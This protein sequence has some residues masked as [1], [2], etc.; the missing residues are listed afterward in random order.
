MTK[1]SS[2]LVTASP[3]TRRW[4]EI[5]KSKVKLELPTVKYYEKMHWASFKNTSTNR[6]FAY[7][8]PTTRQIRLFTKLS[9]SSDSRLKS[10]PSTGEWAETYPSIFNIRSERDTEKAIH[11]II[12]SHN[13]DSWKKVTCDRETL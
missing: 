1:L 13:I 5:I 8:N 9:A 3:E 10:T 11:L 12:K 4:L 6:R 7:L 2:V